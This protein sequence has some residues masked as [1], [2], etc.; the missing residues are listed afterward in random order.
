VAVNSSVGRGVSVSGS[1]VNVEARVGESGGASIAP[2]GWKGVGVGSAFGF[3]VTSTKLCPEPLEEGVEDGIVHEERM[4]RE[5]IMKARRCFI[6]KIGVLLQLE[7]A[8]GC[9]LTM[10]SV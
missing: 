3:G 1:G 8:S 9:T 4:M 7:I 5:N 6:I 2:A 10:T